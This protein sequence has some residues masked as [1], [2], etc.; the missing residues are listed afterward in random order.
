MKNQIE[1]LN[2][3]GKLYPLWSLNIEVLIIV[4][5]TKKGYF[6]K[7][8]EQKLTDLTKI[9]ILLLTGQFSRKFT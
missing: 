3:I 5:Q 7:V 8:L 9:T 2:K 6:S 4:S 1:A